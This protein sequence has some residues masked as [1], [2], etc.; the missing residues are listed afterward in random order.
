[1]PH[2]TKNSAIGR[3]TI[4][5]SILRTIDCP[6]TIPKIRQR[7]A[8]T[9]RNVP[10]S[11]RASITETT[12][13]IVTT[14]TATTMIEFSI[15]PMK[16]RITPSRV[17]AL[18]SMSSWVETVRPEKLSRIAALIESTSSVFRAV[19]IT[20]ETVPARS[21]TDCAVGSGRMTA[22]A[23][24]W[25]ASPRIP[26]TFIVRPPTEMVAPTAIGIPPDSFL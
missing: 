1:M 10:I 5:P 22:F 2:C 9:A 6:A 3:A 25:G 4:V 13:T 14:T 7:R 15:T 20:E 18:R 21:K 17:E 24:S 11:R 23:N 19:R 26:T 8:P 16:A 12:T